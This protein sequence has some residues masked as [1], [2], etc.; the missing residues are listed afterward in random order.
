MERGIFEEKFTRFGIQLDI[1]L[2]EG[3]GIV[4]MT[5]WETRKKI[6]PMKKLALIHKD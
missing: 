6:M 3:K 5:I 1:Q 4:K 2:E